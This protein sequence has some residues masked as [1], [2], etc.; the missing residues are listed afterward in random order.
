MS[1][2]K[3]GYRG[4]DDTRLSPHAAD[5][6][7]A[8]KQ[9]TAERALTC[10][11]P[12]KEV[13]RSHRTATLAMASMITRRKGGGKANHVRAYQC[14]AGH[15]HITSAPLKQSVRQKKRLREKH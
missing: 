12:E 2:N 10:N 13:F 15:W 11:T 6:A 9:A 4:A 1:K 7:V 8:R 14:P 5:R 3:S